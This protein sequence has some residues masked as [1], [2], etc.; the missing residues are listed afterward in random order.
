MFTLVTISAIAMLPHLFLESFWNS[1]WRYIV[2]VQITVWKYSSKVTTVCK[3]HNTQS[4]NTG[5]L[6]GK[7]GEI[8]GK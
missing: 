4:T 8:F 3:S 7:N 1:S 6:E 2:T 5:L